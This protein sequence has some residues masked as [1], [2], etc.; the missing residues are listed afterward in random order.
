MRNYADQDASKAAHQE[1]R[2]CEV[3]MMLK[4]ANANKRDCE[5]ASVRICRS[6]KLRITSLAFQQGS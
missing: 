5:P 2:D 4:T 1:V 3:A 6:V